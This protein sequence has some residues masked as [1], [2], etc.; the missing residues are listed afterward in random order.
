[1]TNPIGFHA[2]PT[3]AETEAHIDAVKKSAA[4]A[5]KITIDEIAEG[6]K[7]DPF[8][9]AYADASPPVWTATDPRDGYRFGPPT[10]SAERAA[11]LMKLAVT[12]ASVPTQVGGKE[13]VT[14][15]EHYTKF[16]VE[17]ITF[18]MG[19][20][21]SFEIG[22]IVKYAVRAG[23]KLY[24]GKTSTESEILDLEKVRRYAEMR[25]NKLQN[26]AVL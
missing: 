19:N 1:M 17:P 15:P 3:T 26:K 25:I 22:N 6:L 24:P 12:P 7:G 20:G 2:S 16:A 8:A 9:S 18:I 13:V 23:S 5:N 14:R 11:E 10:I 4:R 21:L